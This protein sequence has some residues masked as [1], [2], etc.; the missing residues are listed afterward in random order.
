MSKLTI[1]AAAAAG[2]VLGA[3]AGRERYEQI[4]TQSTKVWESPT[5]QSGV[6]TAT[7]QAKHAAT[8]A[9][10]AAASAAASAGST[11]VEKVVEKVKGDD[12]DDESPVA[13]AAPG[14][15]AAPGSL[16]GDPPA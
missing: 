6:D 8:A 2:Y 3:R 4:K 16:L 12:T 9:G 11:V 10:S 1:L 15:H 13:P 7:T 5:V 14:A